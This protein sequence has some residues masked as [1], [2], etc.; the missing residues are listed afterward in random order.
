[1]AGTPSYIIIMNG[2]SL[3]LPP[4]LP[5]PVLEVQFDS[6]SYTV[7][8][9]G[10]TSLT[11]VLNN[12]AAMDITVDIET[13]PGSAGTHVCNTHHSDRCNPRK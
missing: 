10:N 12:E 11:V 1:M 8:E 3:S 13:I 4:S 6:D 5:P 7:L 2:I 9:G